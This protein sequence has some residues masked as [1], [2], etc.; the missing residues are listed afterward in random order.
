MSRVPPDFVVNIHRMTRA[1][2]QRGFGLPLILGTTKD[3]P[4]TLYNSISQVAQDFAVTTEEYRIAQRIFGQSP[5]PQQVAIF[6]ILPEP[7][8]DLDM[9]LLTTINEIVEINDDW[10]FLVCTENSDDVVRA[11]GGFMETQYKLFFTTTQNLA[12]VNRL[13]YDRTA[14]MY[15]EDPRAYVAEGLVALG[16]TTDPGSI[17]FKFKQVR[18]V[19][20]S[21]IRATELSELH[22]NNGF[23]YIRKKGALQTTEGTVTTGE[24]I[25]IMMASDF[26]KFRMEEEFA[27]LAINTPKIPYDDRGIAMLVSVVDKVLS[28]AGRMKIIKVDEYGNYVYGI[29]ALRRD[30]KLTNYVA[31]RIYNG[32][33]WWIV[34]A[35][36]IHEGTITGRFLLT[37]PQ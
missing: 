29:N 21:E 33:D 10:Y 24:F 27:L 36:A 26:I 19:L 12:L 7:N 8:D 1:V 14:V 15:H 2:T 6:S 22:R 4:Y 32:L 31:N 5:S 17:T 37:E 28:V 3:Q 20:A 9:L 34:V 35:G 18:G 13:E 11:L 16:A 23:T 30:Q 25:D